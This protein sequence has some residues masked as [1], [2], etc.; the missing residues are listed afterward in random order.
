MKISFFGA[1]VT[2][3]KE[4]YVIKFNKSK[5]SKELIKLLT[6]EFPDIIIFSS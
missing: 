3:Q 4:G 1:S 2:A 5:P 6:K